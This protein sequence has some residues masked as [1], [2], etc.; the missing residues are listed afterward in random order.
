[1][2]KRKTKKQLRAEYDEYKAANE[3]KQ[4]AHL[5]A[6][7]FSPRAG[8]ATAIDEWRVVEY[9]DGT[10]ADVQAKI[11]HLRSLAD[12]AKAGDQDQSYAMLTAQMATLDMLF[13]MLVTKAGAN[14]QAG[15][16]DATERYLKLALKAQSQ[17][18]CT[19]EALH[20]HIHPRTAT[21]IK[22]DNRANNMQVNN[23]TSARKDDNAPNKLLERSD[24]N[25]LGFSTTGEAVADDSS[26]ETVGTLDGSTDTGG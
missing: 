13:N 25:R 21:F 3:R 7:T 8:A 23:D 17:A 5:A 22:Q 6:R 2:A 19:A 14:S 18:R 9:P 1:M 16:L 24:G 15:Y 26:M 4:M 20:E 11:D 10:R 12:A